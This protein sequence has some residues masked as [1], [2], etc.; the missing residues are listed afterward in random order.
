[1]RVAMEPL[2]YAAGVDVFFYGKSST[3]LPARP[4]LHYN[5][6]ALLCQSVAV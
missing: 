1:M 3:S 2:T 6:L 4:S 5:L